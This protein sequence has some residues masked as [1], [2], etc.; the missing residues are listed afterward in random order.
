MRSLSAIKRDIAHTVIPNA[1]AAVQRAGFSITDIDGAK[2][3]VDNRY[4]FY[5]ATGYWRTLDSSLSGYGTNTLIAEARIGEA[6]RHVTL[7]PAITETPAGRDSGGIF[8]PPNSDPDPDKSAESAG[9]PS[10]S[11]L[12]RPVL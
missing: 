9:V 10:S 1:V 2:H 8:E 7:V 3:H 6:L 5:P 4:V 11:M 12:A